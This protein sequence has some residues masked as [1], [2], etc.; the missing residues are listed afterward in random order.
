MRS[1]DHAN[2]SDRLF[3]SF[4][5]GHAGMLSESIRVIFLLYGITE[6][7]A[8]TAHDMYYCIAIGVEICGDFV[9]RG[10]AVWPKRI[11]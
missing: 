1:V 11:L 8:E 6:G 5:S 3:P 2:R 10:L 7:V 9:P 4:R